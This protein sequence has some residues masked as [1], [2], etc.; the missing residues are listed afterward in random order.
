MQIKFDTLIQSFINDQVGVVEGFLSAQLAGDLKQNLL[1][2]F[3]SQQF[4]AA[5]IG[6]QVLSDVNAAF[7]RDQIYWLDKSHNDIFEN[8]FFEL[9]DQFVAYLNQYCYTG[10]RSY[11]FHYTFY[12]IGSYYK[13]HLD[14]FKNNDSRKF[15]MILYLNDNWQQGDGGELCVHHA[16]KPLQNIA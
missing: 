1:R 8:Q 4:H 14:Q 9:M 11:E 5:G 16:C 13:K 6:N 10:I 7:R 15:S 2:L 3:S 12:E